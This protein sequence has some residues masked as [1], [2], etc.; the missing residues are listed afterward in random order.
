MM[1]GWIRVPYRPRHHVG[2]IIAIPLAISGLL[3]LVVA[4]PSWVGW[5]TATNTLALLPFVFGAPLLSAVQAYESARLEEAA[6]AATWV[7]RTKRVRLRENVRCLA[8]SWMAAALCVVTWLATARIVT[9]LNPHGQARASFRPVLGYVALAVLAI[10]IGHL[11][12]KL[13]AHLA[14]AVAT[15]LVLVLAVSIYATQYGNTD[16]ALVIPVLPVAGLGIGAAVT[17]AAALVAP[18]GPRPGLGPVGVAAAVALGVI[19]AAGLSDRVVLRSD[20]DEAC[21]GADGTTICVWREHAAALEPLTEISEAVRAVAPEAMELP[22]RIDEF[23]LNG[24]VNVSRSLNLD[25]RAVLDRAALTTEYVLTL[26]NHVFSG[27]DNSAAGAAA[28]SE[29]EA[30]LVVAAH[31]GITDAEAAMGY[32]DPA[33]VHQA[34]EV[35]ETGDARDHANI[36]YETATKDLR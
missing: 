34:R 13:Q 16:P 19:A 35:I 7:A 30:L 3:V 6:V 28:R 11:I 14:I 10:A 20:V 12:G 5:P 32:L 2:L 9:E 17:T 18:F 26:S 29:L 25:N 27:Y 36:L 22:D 1:V 23:G 33:H 24:T 8:G 15:A 31:P 21:A 4:A